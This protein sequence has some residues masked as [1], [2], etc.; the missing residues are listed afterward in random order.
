MRQLPYLLGGVI[1]LALVTVGCDQP[2]NV[3]APYVERLVVFGF[4]TNR[5][6]TQ[7][8][9][10]YTTYDPARSNPASD[11]VDTVVRD[12]DVVVSGA[13]GDVHFTGVTIPREDKSRYHDDLLV[14][15]AHPFVLE[16]GRTYALR[17]FDAAGGSATSSVTVPKQGRIQILNSY[18]LSGGGNSGENIVVYGWIRELTYGLIIRLFLIYDTVEGG[19]TVQHQE[20]MPTSVTLDDDGAETYYY[21]VLRR[22]TTSGIIVD[23][24]EN[25]T[26]VFS[27]FAYFHKLGDLYARYPAGSVHVKRALVVLSQVDQNLF[28]YWKL[29]NGFEDPYSI[30][31]DQPD[32]TNIQGGRG[33]FGALVEDSLTVQLTLREE[34]GMMMPMLERSTR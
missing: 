10:V 13:N 6:D 3:K 22:R 30:R 28:T 19:V 9:R 23:K 27:S 11:T 24:E 33:I 8:V 21:P 15:E 16:T 26:T 20:E 29:V 4:L 34:R 25:E 32:Y 14:Y 5:T 7:Y 31:E 1:W 12:A 17:V 18:V 2:F